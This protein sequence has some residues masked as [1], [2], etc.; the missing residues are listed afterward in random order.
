MIDPAAS[1]L[2][3]F[4]TEMARL[5]GAAGLSQFALAQRLNYSVSQITKVEI[6]QRI[7]KPDLA[8]KLDE[9]LEANGLFA[10]LQPLVERSSALPW[11]RDLVEVEGSA[12]QI[13]MYESYLMPGLFQTE[14]YARAAIE[15]Y[16]PTMTADD[17]EQA[18]AL[19]M[20]RQDILDR[21]DAP[22][23]WAVLDE[24]VLLREVGSSATMRGQ[25][26]HLLEL[27][28]LPNVV[29]QVIP[30]AAGLCCAYGRAFMLLSFRHQNDLAYLEDIGAARYIREQEEVARYSLIFDH[31][32]GHALS[33]TKTPGLI[34]GLINHG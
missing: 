3:F 9:I 5:R 11:F 23:I 12:N 28:E 24:S 29:V 34:G 19:R 33:D 8:Q 32:R 25:C 20:T 18:V 6:C 22:Q 7:P 16:R 4:A 27:C 15:V 21:A 17:A 1:P 2:A 13:K 14:A 31:L 26:R 30:N 10:R